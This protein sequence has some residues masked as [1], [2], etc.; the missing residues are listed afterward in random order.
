M[1]VGVAVGVGAGVDVG[2]GV[3]VGGGTGVTVGR[4]VADGSA[5][6]VGL[7]TRSAPSSESELERA[8]AMIMAIT[9]MATAAKMARR[10]ELFT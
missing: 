6:A 4:E 3:I 10:F 2:A 7:A 1:G 8:N 9:A 5:V